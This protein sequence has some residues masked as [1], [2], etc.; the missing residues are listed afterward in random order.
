MYTCRVKKLSKIP[1]FSAKFTPI[2]QISHNL[3]FL[4]KSKKINVVFLSNSHS[5]NEQ[6][7]M[8]EH[9]TK[10]MLLTLQCTSIIHY[11]AKINPIK[12]S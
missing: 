1:T 7:H 10:I 3:S 6:Y 8:V 2:Y 11:N 4:M 9:V 12:S 5:F